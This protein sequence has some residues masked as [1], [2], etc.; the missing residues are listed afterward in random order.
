MALNFHGFGQPQKKFSRVTSSVCIK[1]WK[2]M[3]E[4]AV[5][6][7]I[8]FTGTFWFVSVGVLSCRKRSE[9][10]DTTPSGCTS[11]MARTSCHRSLV[12]SLRDLLWI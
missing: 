10:P 5:I 8:T 12:L 11:C 7:A 1:K 4:L 6:D 2:L 9:L 3:N